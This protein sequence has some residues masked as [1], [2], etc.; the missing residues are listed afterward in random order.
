ML[1]LMRIDF[2][3]DQYDCMR[4]YAYARENINFDVMEYIMNEEYKLSMN[5]RDLMMH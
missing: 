3:F 5:M 2:K 4:I 1:F